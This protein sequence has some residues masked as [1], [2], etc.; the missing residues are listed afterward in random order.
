LS[1]RSGKLKPVRH[2]VAVVHDLV[3]KITP[4]DVLESEHIA[5]TLRWLESTDDV[6][7]RSKP[8]LPERHLVSYV[9]VLDRDNFDVFLVDHVNAG[10]FL[11][12]GG[13]VEPDE[14]PA[15]TARR[16]CREELGIEASFSDSSTPAFVTVTTTVGLDAGHTDVSL[17]FVSDGSRN[18]EMTLDQVEFCGSR[19]WTLEEV[20]STTGERFDPHFHRFMTKA[21]WLDS[22]ARPAKGA[23]SSVPLT[24]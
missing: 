4:L 2:S 7:R 8:A 23:P 14:H 10:L 20:T 5:D 22:A 24:S 16:E 13:H 3:A 19:W 1:L 9:V 17:W 11:P 15:A 18:L 12:P 6:F 21:L